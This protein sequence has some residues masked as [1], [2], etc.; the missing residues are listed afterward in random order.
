M[1]FLFVY[2]VLFENILCGLGVVF[3]GIMSDFKV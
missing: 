2:N 3:Y 1:R